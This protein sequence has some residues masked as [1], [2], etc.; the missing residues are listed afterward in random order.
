VKL[1]PVA[2]YALRRDMGVAGLPPNRPAGERLC[3]HRLI[4]SKRKFR[5]LLLLGSVLAGTF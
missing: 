5:A 4:D 2:M 1:M 3:A